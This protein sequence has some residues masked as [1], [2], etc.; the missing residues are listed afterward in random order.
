MGNRY[1]LTRE[2]FA[3]QA[4]RCAL[5]KIILAD[6]DTIENS[7]IF[8]WLLRERGGHPGQILQ[9]N[10][11]TVE[12]LIEASVAAMAAQLWLITLCKNHGRRMA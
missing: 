3:E 1:N 9:R 6:G 4:G 12:N 8:S 11:T 10:R 5:A 7:Q 2:N